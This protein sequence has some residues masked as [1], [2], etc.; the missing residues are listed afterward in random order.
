MNNALK[1]V[2]EE[3]KSN[4]YELIG[5]AEK[6][7]EMVDR[8]YDLMDTLPEAKGIRDLHP[9]RLSGSREKLFMFLSGWLGGPFCFMRSV[10]RGIDP[11]SIPTLQ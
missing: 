10:L 4:L 5:G 11:Q 8:F 9:E 1:E 3:A 7:R 2:S 6:L